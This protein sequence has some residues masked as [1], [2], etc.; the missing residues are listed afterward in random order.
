[1]KMLLTLLVF[2]ALSIQAAP[3]PNVVIPYVD[4]MGYGDPKCFNAKSR[5][6]TPAIDRLAAEG[7]MFADAQLPMRPALGHGMAC[8]R[9]VT[10]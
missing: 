3:K 7:L 9:G 1:M 2:V 5:L 4:D 6:K 8:S 10:R